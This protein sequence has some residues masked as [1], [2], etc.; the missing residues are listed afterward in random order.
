M[1]LRKATKR[2]LEV[3]KPSQDDLAEAKAFNV[4]PELPDVTECLTIEY[5][6][7]PLAI[8]GN[9]VNRVWFVTSEDIDKLNYKDVKK[10]IKLIK[11]FRDTLLDL[12]PVLYNIVWG[13][14]NSHIK[15]LR[16]IGADFH[17]INDKFLLFTIEEKDKY[18]LDGYYT[19]CHARC[20]NVNGRCTE[21][22]CNSFSDR[23]RKA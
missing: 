21:R 12:Y 13:D 8:G 23:P 15:F 3:F 22:P 20:L 1:I 18:V 6:N 5:D 7:K 4:P 19:N 2:D 9:V 11:T 14:N 16:L 17:K 10:F